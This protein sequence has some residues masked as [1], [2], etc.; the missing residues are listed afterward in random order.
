[1]L[2]K[3]ALISTGLTLSAYS[4]AAPH[5]LYLTAKDFN[6]K[7]NALTVDVA[8]DAVNDTIDIFDMRQAEG[9]TDKSAGD[10]LGFH[11]A[12]QYAWHP[13]WSVEGAFW[14][15]E[16][17]YSQDTNELQS[18]LMAVRYTPD[19]NLKKNDA[20]SFRLSLWGNTSDMLSKTTPT[21]VNDFQF[22]QV[23]VHSPEDLQLQ[24]DSIFSRKLDPM[25][26]LNAFFSLGYSQVEISDLDVQALYQ[27]C[28]MDI[29]VQS[30]NQFTGQLASPCSK[31]GLTFTELQVSGAAD[32]FGLNIQDDLNYDSYFASAGASWNWRYRQFESQLAYQYQYFWRNKIDDRVSYF[33]NSPIKDNH[34]IGAKFSYDFNPHI[35]GFLKGEIYQHN[36]IGYVPFLYNGVTASRLDKRYGLA[37]L[38]VQFRAF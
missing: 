24:L 21:K 37:S 14:N 3:V 34:S 30:N 13:E 19:W 26:Q 6:S 38:G 17:E 8:I 7:P 18:Y 12:A 35:T 23:H 11:L 32:Q 22:K 5:D 36:L 28:L 25:N 33:G 20:L 16:I 15:R 31:D 9:I 4:F 29:N 1:M 2:K 10:Y 27:G